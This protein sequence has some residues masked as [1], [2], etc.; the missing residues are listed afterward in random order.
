MPLPKP[1]AALLFNNYYD[2]DTGDGVLNSNTDPLNVFMIAADA[3]FTFGEKLNSKSKFKAVFKDATEPTS[4]KDLVLTEV[5]KE[6]YPSPILLQGEPNNPGFEVIP[7]PLFN[8]SVGFLEVTSGS[9]ALFLEEAKKVAP[10]EKLETA[11]D[12]LKNNLEVVSPYK[13]DIKFPRETIV[14]LDALYSNKT[15]DDKLSVPYVT[16][17]D[18]VTTGPAMAGNK[19]FFA[20]GGGNLDFGAAE[21]VDDPFTNS[22]NINDLNDLKNQPGVDSS[23][24]ENAGEG[25][26]FDF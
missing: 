10:K 5:S 16:G 2:Y 17:K 1:Q 12:F 22:N 23:N 26:P 15:I 8:T 11:I 7:Y 6:E 9:L 24:F 21:V 20:G 18:Q 4:E 19:Q 13:A 3:Y 14:V 25:V